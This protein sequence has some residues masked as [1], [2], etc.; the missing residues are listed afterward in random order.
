METSV[1]IFDKYFYYYRF[2]LQK[3]YRVCQSYA[4]VETSNQLKAWHRNP[5]HI[6]LVKDHFQLLNKD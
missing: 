5:K 6:E 3:M 4:I 1:D 2:A